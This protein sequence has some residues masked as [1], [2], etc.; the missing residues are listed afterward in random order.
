MRGWI[1]GLAAAAFVLAGCEPPE[2][3]GPVG[4]AVVDSPAE[5]QPLPTAVDATVRELR[6]IAATGGYRELAQLAGAY[7]AFR[8]NNA[9]MGHREYWN[10]KERT[11]DFPAAQVGQL[12]RR[13]YAVSDSP[14]GKIYIWPD[15]AILKPEEITASHAREID[16]WLGAGQADEL[17]N[18]AIWPGY[19][20]GIREDGTWL[21]FVSG[22]G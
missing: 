4:A 2:S 9:G 5:V 17:R 19:V 16:S 7:P 13:R 14:E 3:A 11:G 20:L 6:E 10:L 12:L 21:Y 22:S 15:L 18:G 1:A 8:S